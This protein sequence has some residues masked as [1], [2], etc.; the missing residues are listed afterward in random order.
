ML[1][2]QDRPLFGA[3]LAIAFTLLLIWSTAPAT[4]S[5]PTKHTSKGIEKYQQYVEGF[6]NYVAHDSISLFTGASRS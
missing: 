1:K 5:E 6:W 3:L 2:P 4:Q